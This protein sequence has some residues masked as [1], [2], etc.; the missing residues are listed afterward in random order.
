[1]KR[2]TILRIGAVLVLSAL[3]VPTIVFTRGSPTP[4]NPLP[5]ET[6]PTETSPLETPP[7]DPSLSESE[8][9][10]S[11][12]VV[13]DETPN[14][15][16]STTGSFNGSLI[17]DFYSPGIEPF[18]LQINSS[19]GEL[20]WYYTLEGPELWLVDSQRLSDGNYMFLSNNG[21]YV[22]T[23]GGEL[24]WFH[25]EPLVSHHC[26]VTDKGV[27]IVSASGNYAKEISWDH[28]TLWEWKAEDYIQ[29]Y[30]PANYVGLQYSWVNIYALTK[31]GIT[32]EGYVVGPDWTHMNSAQRLPDGSTILS[33]R[34]QDLVIQ[35]D[36]GGSVIRS[37]GALILKAQHTPV[38][39]SQGR[40]WVFDNGNGRVVRF[41]KYGIVEWEYKGPSDRP[42]EAVARGGVELINGG[43]FIIIADGDNRR[44]LIVRSET[45]EVVYTL[46]FEDCGHLSFY[47]A[48]Y[49]E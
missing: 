3:L 4:E 9:P 26:E 5:A 48:H 43:E 29:H 49:T 6:P 34:T 42:I 16:W 21:V 2:G 15:S 8:L 22:V 12:R 37:W 36:K 17:L 20:E 11:G 45:K 44:V 24:V 14:I 40:L 13:I 46:Q 41:D 31:E 32:L 18:T 19:T 39:D 35:V 23:P 27:L 30:T 33:L 28:E 25:R 38:L 7:T 47:R 10:F 1:M